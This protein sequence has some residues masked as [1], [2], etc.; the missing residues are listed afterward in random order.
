MPAFVAHGGAD[1]IVPPTV[2]G[3]PSAVAYA[4]YLG[5]SPDTITWKEYRGAGHTDL[6][7]GDFLVRVS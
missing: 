5:I 2:G 6:P 4:N 3:K 1:R 7:V